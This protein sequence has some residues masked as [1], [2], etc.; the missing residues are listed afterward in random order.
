LNAEIQKLLSLPLLGEKALVV[1]YPGNVNVGHEIKIIAHRIR[2]LI[3]PCRTGA[4][5]NIAPDGSREQTG[6][7]EKHAV[8][9]TGQRLLGR[10][11]PSRNP[12]NIVIVAPAIFEI[13][14]ATGIFCKFWNSV[15]GI[16]TI[17]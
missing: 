11:M 13:K 1:I 10:A 17:M 15:G 14:Q 5:E 3:D 8:G 2:G 7:A 9:L 6:I 12:F 16:C 4:E